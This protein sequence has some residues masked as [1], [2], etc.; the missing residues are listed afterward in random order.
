M[1]D[2]SEN[3]FQNRKRA[4][5]Y[6]ANNKLKLIWKLGGISV[7]DAATLKELGKNF[8]SKEVS[9]NLGLQEETIRLLNKLSNQKIR[10]HLIEI[11]LQTSKN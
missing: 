3:G 6:L 4:V 11:I 10:D 8:E 2:N 5:Q 9:T 7:E 1:Q